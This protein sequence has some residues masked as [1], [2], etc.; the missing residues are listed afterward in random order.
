MCES[1]LRHQKMQMKVA[2][3]RL[4]LCLKSPIHPIIFVYEQQAESTLLTLLIISYSISLFISLPCIVCDSLYSGY[5]FA[6]WIPKMNICL[7]TFAL[8][9]RSPR[10][11]HD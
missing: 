4:F 7:C 9:L 1:G 8:W 3:G 10:G 11:F 2:Y 5:D 6:H